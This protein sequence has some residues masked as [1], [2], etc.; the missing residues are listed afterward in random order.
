[1]TTAALALVCLAGCGG[2]TSGDSPADARRSADGWTYGDDLSSVISAPA[3][4]GEDRVLVAVG[5]R[6]A[7]RT[8]A[9]QPALP[10]S[11]EAIHE[12]R[13][14]ALDLQG[15]EQ[16][17]SQPVC[18]PLRIDK[19]EWVGVAATDDRGALVACNQLIRLDASGKVLWQTPAKG[20]HVALAADGTAVSFSADGAALFA[21]E[22]SGSIRWTTAPLI[23]PSSREAAGSRLG[24]QAS[25]IIV[26]KNVYA[27]CDRCL[28]NQSGIAKVEL[29]SGNL[30]FLGGAGTAP[31]EYGGLAG[32]SSVVYL[33][34]R[35]LVAYAEQPTVMFKGAD[36]GPVLVAAEGPVA[37]VNQDGG[38]RLRIGER[39]SK[40]TLPTLSGPVALLAPESVLLSNGHVVDY[41]GNLKFKV[42][43]TD[44]LRSP[45]LAREGALLVTTKEGRLQ[46]RKAAVHGF[47]PGAPWP[48]VGGGA[49]NQ[50]RTQQ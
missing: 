44:V 26:G 28:P 46:R 29:A 18:D 16:W 39:V 9:T 13:V 20:N 17:R 21:V 40:K 37:V 48:V 22:P 6:R 4:L 27:P 1:V 24:V 23:T 32:G 5:I 7:R 10:Y 36:S 30:E 50:R 33:S 8:N 38:P 47:Q 45:P 35:S 14:V 15:K 43:S 34:S 3:L 12:V 42:E 41:D 49:S 19:A 25:A 2:K 11:D 31:G